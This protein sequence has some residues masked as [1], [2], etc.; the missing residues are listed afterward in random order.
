MLW[1]ALRFFLLVP[2][3]LYVWWQ[4]LPAYAWVLGQAGGG[5]L[6][7][8]FD[9][10]IA[11]MMVVPQG[12]FKTQTELVYIVDGAE[13]AIAVGMLATNIAPFVALVLATPNLTWSHRGKALIIGCLVLAAAHLGFLLT[14]YNVSRAEVPVAFGQICITLPFPLWIALA[15]WDRITTLVFGRAPEP[16]HPEPETHPDTTP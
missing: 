7:S 13:R 1:L 6:R 5:L 8:L 4:L 14:A 15:Y 12:L 2:M 9:V 11:S 10:P 3:C 16:T